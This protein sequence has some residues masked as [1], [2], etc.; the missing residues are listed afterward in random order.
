MDDEEKARHD[1]SGDYDGTDCKHCGRERVMKC[2]NG[3]RVCEKCGWDQEADD[4][5][6]GYLDIQP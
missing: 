5:A 6:Y 4:Y 2:N 1:W 3:R